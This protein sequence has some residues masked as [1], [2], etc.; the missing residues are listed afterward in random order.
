MQVATTINTEYND[1]QPCVKIFCFLLKSGSLNL[2]VKRIYSMVVL[3][4]FV[5]A[6]V[7]N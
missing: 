3:R 6:S 1:S 4:T 2:L 5:L 7:S